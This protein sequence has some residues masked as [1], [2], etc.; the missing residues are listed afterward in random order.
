MRWGVLGV[1]AV[2]LV[3]LG[4]VAYVDLYAR[5]VYVVLG[6]KPML[7]WPKDLRHVW[8]PPGPATF[9]CVP[10]EREVWVGDLWQ[11]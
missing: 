9:A 1:A 8:E 3:L 10:V 2:L 11:R 5:P 4:A 7:C 6:G